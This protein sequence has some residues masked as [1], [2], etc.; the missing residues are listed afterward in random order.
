MRVLAAL[1]FALA[2]LAPAAV[3]APVLAADVEFEQPELQATITTVH[4]EVTFSSTE[5]PRRV[6]LLTRNRFEDSWFVQEAEIRGGDGRYTAIVDGEGHRVPNTPLGYRF[7]VTTSSGTVL[8]EERQLTVV[9]DRFQWRVLEGRLVRLHWYE[10]GDDFARRALDVGEKAVDDVSRLLGVTE[11]EPIDF[12]VY[13][14]LSAFRRA[15]GPGTPENAAGQANT[16]IRTL[17]ALIQPGQINSSWVRVVIPH[18]LAHLVFNTA[19]A[20]PYHSPPRWLNEGLAVYLSEGYGGAD[21]ARIAAAIARGS[22]MPLDG[23]RAQFPTSSDRFFLSYA[24]SVSAVDFFIRKYG[25]PTLVKLVRSYANGVTDDEAFKAATGA[26]LAAFN[27]AWFA[28]I[29]ARLPQPVGPQPGPT[30]PLPSDWTSS[31]RPSGAATPRGAPS[32][33]PAG[34]SPR[35]PVFVDSPAIP[36]TDGTTTLFIAAGVVALVALV[37]IA[38]AFILRRRASP[39]PPPPGPPPV[40]PPA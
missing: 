28:D 9:D 20:N 14:S 37:V 25:Q 10:G 7:R 6:E 2:L 29:G 15:L 18:E 35:Q 30:G 16:S 12:F 27:A 26:D 3:A 39:P 19:V 36:G 31:P 21:R 38:R 13:S 5:R 4:A 22:L 11:S 40:P 33:S 1:A 17:F 24:E 8:S 34:A 32:G 23:I